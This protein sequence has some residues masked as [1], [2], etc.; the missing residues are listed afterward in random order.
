MRRLGLLVSLLVVALLGLG[1]LAPITSTRAQ[2]AT[3]LAGELEVKIDEG[4]TFGIVP[5]TPL[6]TAPA[7]AFRLRFA[8]GAVWERP[9]D[10]MDEP[11]VSIV[12]VEAGTLVFRSTGP[13]MV[14][15]AGQ[16]DA[17]AESFAADTDVTLSVG[18]STVLGLNPLREIRNDGQV[19]AQ[20]A[21][22]TLYLERLETSLMATPVP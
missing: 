8:P 7:S 14:M 10:A 2:D 9:A 21:T 4:V 5:T 16:N 6:A 18:D 13:L 19:P 22:A 3:P 17:P 11:V 15:R 20:L 12:Y 1:S